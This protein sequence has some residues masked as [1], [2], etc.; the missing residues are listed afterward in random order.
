MSYLIIGLLLFLGV[1][2][3][4]IVAEDWRTRQLQARG[5]AVY[6]GVY[7]VLSL[8]GFALLVYGFG[9]ARETP[10]LLWPLPVALRHA[11]ALLV[12][13]AFVL[14][15]AAYVPGNAIQAR[16]RHP[17]V[18]GVKTWALAH[19]LA[20][21]RLETVVLFGAFLL[22]AVLNFSAARKRD[23]LAAGDVAQPVSKGATVLAVL[24][25]VGAYAVFAVLLHGL[26]IGI[27]PWG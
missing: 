25:G 24:L 16:V 20:T 2:S 6:K 19:L 14:L 3:V 26:L 7:S 1:H 17:M 12:L 21:G 23:R 15:A 10:V 18:L 22:W 13:L 4:R 11:A 8:L 5:E 27:R 9:V